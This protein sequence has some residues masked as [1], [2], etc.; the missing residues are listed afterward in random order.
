MA[1]ERTRGFVQEKDRRLLKDGAGDCNALLLTARQLQ[2]ALADHRPVALGKLADEVID[3]R[4][5]RRLVDL[6]LGGIRTPVLDVVEDRI[7]E[8]HGILRHHADRRTQALLGHIAN[9]LA[10]DGHATGGDIVEA[11]QD[12]PYGRLPRPRRANNGHHLASWHL[13]RDVL[14]DRPVRLVSEVNILET[15]RPAIDPQGLGVRLVDDLR[16]LVEQREHVLQIHETL[17]DLAIDH[18]HEV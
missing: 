16:M 11:E 1:V 4:Q 12:A 8:E 18:A 14:Q 7:V 2:P 13:E 17:L 5:S 15:D 9:V 10:V 3:L 6:L